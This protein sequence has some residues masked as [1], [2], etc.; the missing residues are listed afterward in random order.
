M[1]LFFFISSDMAALPALR[2]TQCEDTPMNDS[3]NFSKR[4]KIRVRVLFFAALAAF[5]FWRARY[6]YSYN[7][8]PFCITLAQRLYQGDALFRDEWHVCQNFGVVLLPIYTI[9]R[10][11]VGSN[12]G[13]LLTF[14]FLYCLLWLCCMVVVFRTVQRKSVF[15]AY[16]AVVYLGLFSPLD[17]MTLSYT[18]IGLMSILMILCIFSTKEKEQLNFFWG[19]VCGFFAAVLSLCNPYMA[20]PCVIFWLTGFIGTFSKNNHSVIKRNFFFGCLVGISVWLIPYLVILFS[21]EG[22]GEILKNIPAIMDDP[23]HTGSSLIFVANVMRAYMLGYSTHLYK[24]TFVALLL[25][26]LSKYLPDKVA[27]GCRFL[28]WIVA[29]VEFF[30]VLFDVI[31]YATTAH[32]NYQIKDI[33]LLG[34]IAFLLLKKKPWKLFGIYYGMGM[35]YTFCTVLAS[36]TGAMALYM[37]M[38]TCGVSGIIFVSLLTNEFFNMDLQYQKLGIVKNKVVIAL[39]ILIALAQLS[40]ELY[41]R[42]YRTYWD[43]PLSE[44]NVQIED[45]P[46]KGLITSRDNAD[47]YNQDVQNFKKLFADESTDGKTFLSYTSAPWYYLYVDLRYDTFSAW[48]FGYDNKLADRL[49]NYYELNGKKYPDYIYVKNFD[50]ELSTEIAK[51]YR[52]KR[53]LSGDCALLCKLE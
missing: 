11:V 7:D 32:F 46:A 30:L 42:M 41:I 26:I 1:S 51:L 14:R 22:L 16:F 48:T 52:I 38:A 40:E 6:G 8:E 27:N 23:E 31:Q 20:I 21:R 37:G 3:L 15:G 9:F 2:K 35:I 28:L 29:C 50:G 53:N 49:Q 25:C 45:G 10:L 13:I 12:T 5:L 44:L 33:P 34:L 43:A 36:N 18:S 17:Y 39:L 4:I 24:L 19:G 47:T